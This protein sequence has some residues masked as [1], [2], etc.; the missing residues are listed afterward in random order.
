MAGDLDAPVV[1]VLAGGRGTRLGGAKPAALLAGRPL[2]A[3]PL[4]AAAAAGLEAVVV[5]K[6]DSP[7]PPLDVPV[8]VEPDA[9]VHPLLGVVCALERAGGR[10][11]IAV[12]CDMPFLTGAALRTLAAAPAPAAAAGQPLLARYGPEQLA[13]LRAA[14]REEAPM[15]RTLA[16]LDPRP[17]ALDPAVARNVNDPDALAAAERELA[18]WPA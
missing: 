6:R 14:L 5:A 15:R 13:P 11:V 18:G 9:P 3:W 17:V 12:G 4:A 10:D 2:I 1:A 16:A 7:L 8:W